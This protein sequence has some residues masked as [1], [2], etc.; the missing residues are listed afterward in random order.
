MRKESA[1]GR[2]KPRLISFFNEYVNKNLHI[3]CNRRP[4]LKKQN[5]MDFTDSTDSKSPSL[6]V[7]SAMTAVRPI[8]SDGRARYTIEIFFTN[9]IGFRDVSRELFARP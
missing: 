4:E 8:V 6:R 1:A 3:R 7:V 2:A 9:R 5:A